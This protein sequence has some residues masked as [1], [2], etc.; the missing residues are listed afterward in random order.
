ML[1]FVGV[2]AGADHAQARPLTPG[3]LQGRSLCCLRT[4][5]VGVRTG[6]VVPPDAPC[7]RLLPKGCGIGPKARSDARSADFSGAN[8][9]R[10]HLGVRLVEAEEEDDV[11]LKADPTHPCF[12]LASCAPEARNN[13]SDDTGVGARLQ[14]ATGQ[15]ARLVDVAVERTVCPDGVRRSGGCTGLLN[16][17]AGPERERALQRVTWLQSLP[18]PWD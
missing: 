2:L 9:G 15:G 8:L 3:L 4:E 14:G 12:P 5:Q 1:T 6:C 10:A 18:F 16:L 11:R 13:V 7:R 17:Q